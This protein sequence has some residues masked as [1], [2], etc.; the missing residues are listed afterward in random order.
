MCTKFEENRSTK[1]LFL[2]GLKLFPVW[3]EEEEEEEKK[4]KEY[5]ENQT[6]FENE[7]LTNR[8]RD[9]FQ[10]WYARWPICRA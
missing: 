7:Y 8:W 3:C 10:I 9:F 1:R 2:R 6:T 5:E 4:N